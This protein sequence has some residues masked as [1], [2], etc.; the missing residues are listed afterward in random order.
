[1]EPM[2]SGGTAHEGDDRADAQELGAGGASGAGAAAGRGQEIA[3]RVI[4]LQPAAPGG[5]EEAAGGRRIGAID[6][7]P[8][9][10]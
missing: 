10:R 4:V 8:S 9:G 1:M 7:V 3:G 5:R 6:P 2:P